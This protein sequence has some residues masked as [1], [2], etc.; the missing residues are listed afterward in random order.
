MKRFFSILS[1]LLVLSA[2]F[3]ASAAGDRG[4]APPIISWQAPAFY[5]SPSSG[6]TALADLSTPLPFVPVTPCRQYSTLLTTKLVDNTPRTVTLSG[7]PCGIPATAKAV[8]VNITIFN[9]AAGSNGVFRADTVSPPTVAW[10]NYPPTETQRGNA[11]VLSTGA[12]AAI[13][14]QINQGGGNVDFVVDVFGWYGYITTSGAFTVANDAA[15]GYAIFGQSSGASGIGV[16]G[17]TSGSGGKGVY[18]TNGTATGFGV[19]GVNSGGVGVRGDSTSNVGVFGISGTSNGV[20]AES[21]T[22]DGL[23]ARGGR[24]GAYITGAHNGVGGVSTGTG[25]AYYG[26]WGATASTTAGAAGVYGVDSSGPA[27]GTSGFGSGVRGSSYS[28]PGV[29]GDSDFAG[30]WGNIWAAGTWIGAGVLGYHAGA[31]YYGVY[32]T[33]DYGGS[34]A[35]YFVEP[36]PTDASKVIRYISLEGPESGTYFRGT[37]RTVGGQAVIEVPESFR[38]VSDEEDLTVQ[39]TPVGALTTMAVMSQDLNSIV[40]RSLKDVSF[41]YL[42]QGVRRAFKG[43]NP[44]SPGGEFTPWGPKAVMQASLPE[45]LKRRLVANGTYN[46]DGTVNMST[47]ERMGWAQK[48]R[49]DEAKAKAAQQAA[50]AKAN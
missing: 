7:A 9:I 14:V 44:I 3:T 23:Y 34:G 30:V 2:T 48:W 1:G 50:A 33:H 24:D 11:G 17:L 12:S 49:D 38:I 26:V 40:V 19:Q 13:V 8:A 47:A 20:W 5:T 25:V 32:S 45:E 29:W 27:S 31:N 37:A 15:S 36:H 6:R 16:Y 35:K 46:T 18:G 41:H 42:V 39:L 4:A 22:L 10:I 21:T 43:F 28:W